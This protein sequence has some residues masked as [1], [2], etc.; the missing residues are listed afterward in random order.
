MGWLKNQV[1]PDF[2]FN[3]LN[4]L[5]SLILTKSERSLEVILKLSD[6]LRYMLYETNAP[7]VALIKELESIK[8]Y[9]DLEKI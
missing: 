5:Y 2:L 3:T 7:Q 4:S 1:Q 9:L 6:L 8:S